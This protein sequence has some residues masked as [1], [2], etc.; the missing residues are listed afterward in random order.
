MK[1]S[2]IGKLLAAALFVP[3]F[4]GAIVALAPQS[5]R[6]GVQQIA[7]GPTPWPSVTS[8]GGNS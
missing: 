8:S 2:R 6:V 3:L 7:N 5:V 1:N 4:A